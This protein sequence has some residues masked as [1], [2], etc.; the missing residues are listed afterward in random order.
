MR[1]AAIVPGVLLLLAAC[2]RDD[3]QPAEP[4]DGSPTEGTETSPTPS[5]PIVGLWERVTTC[6]ERAAALDDAGLGEF[7]AE[8]A[9]GEG[10]IPGVTDPAQIQDPERPC[11]GAVPLKHGHFFT[12]DGL[13]G[14]TDA[15]G[16]QVDDGRF[17][18]V[19]DDT[20]V[21]EKEFG[22]VTFD[23]EVRDDDLFLNP[24]MPACAE[25]GCFAAQWAVSV[26]YPGL[27]WERVA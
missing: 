4:T 5:S 3:Q 15:Q 25:T 16:D 23:F 27:P 6:E 12:E 18:V 21:I 13:F 22:D 14:S 7:A 10:W 8:H 11:E 9:A 20:I 19:D 2:G 1:V 26:A 24:V 17:R